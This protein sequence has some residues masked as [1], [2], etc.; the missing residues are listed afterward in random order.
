MQGL[1][2][3]SKP[4]DKIIKMPSKSHDTIPLTH[5]QYG[6]RV[7]FDGLFHQQSLIQI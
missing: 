5:P 1:P 6:V 4:N 7:G 3:T 2:I